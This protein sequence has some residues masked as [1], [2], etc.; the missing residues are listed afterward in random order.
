MKVLKAIAVA[1]LVLISVQ[2]I[3]AITY[4]PAYPYTQ[5]T[6]GQDIKIEAI[7]YNP[8]GGLTCLG[9]TRVYENKNLL[10]TVDRYFRNPI[11]TS[12][13]G[14]FLVIVHRTI[15]RYPL[16]DFKKRDAEKTA[17]E[18]LKNGEAY[19]SFSLSEVIEFDS[20]Q[21]NGPFYE[22]TYSIDFEKFGE[23]K[24]NYAYWDQSLRIWEKWECLMGDSSDYCLQWMNARDSM[25][26]YKNER[27]VYHQAIFIENNRL[28]IL[29]NQ[30]TAIHLDLV[31]LSLE[32]EA[33]Q[34]VLSDKE[35]FSPPETKKKFH[36][37]K[38]PEE[39]TE[40]ALADGS[41][42]ELRIAELLECEVISF[43]EKEI[44]TVYIGYLLIDEN[45]RCIKFSGRVYDKGISK[46]YTK[47]SVKPAMSAKLE[48]WIMSQAFQTDL[49]PK[50]FDAY[51]FKCIIRLKEK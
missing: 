2:Q 22:W 21:N 11:F 40:P 14:Q 33:I 5:N 47:E 37:Y 51:S 48:N 38:L 12:D 45:G 25:K 18:I 10:Y 41:S 42:L 32:K 28:C 44:Y 15:L 31:D 49:I 24:K 39:F 13:N 27:E 50:G 43:G 17:I 9:V 35:S 23:V 29:S 6:E 19:K 26:I 4:F 7:P 30:N 8:Y 3:K 34:N 36:D 16:E 20:L 1:L 46:Y